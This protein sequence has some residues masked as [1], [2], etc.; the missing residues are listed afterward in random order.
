MSGLSVHL[1]VKVMEY[2]IYLAMVCLASYRL[3]WLL[4]SWRERKSHRTRI[5][6]EIQEKREK[7]IRRSEE[8]PLATRFNKAGNPLFL[9]ALKFQII[10][11]SIFSGVAI[12]YLLGPLINE[13]H[14]SLTIFGLIL[15]MLVATSPML[16]ISLTNVALNKLIEFHIRK[17]HIELFTLFDMLKAELRSLNQQ[18]HVNVYHLLNGSLPYFDSIDSGI[19]KFLRFW[20]V[21]PE[22]AREVFIKEIGGDH[23][24]Q[25]ANILF[26]LDE[27]SRS[28]AVEVIDG[29]SK[30]FS[31]DYFETANRKTE[32]KS[33]AFNVLFFGANI[34]TLIWLIVMVVSMF[35]NTFSQVNL[36][37]Y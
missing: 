18:Q 22:K 34:L 4:T 6:K 33:I 20:K 28:Y 7:V 32:G 16:K 10:R 3:Y 24:E 1:L 14:I 30:V 12:Y 29:A 19:T 35:S 8:T 21:D 15:L 23:A 26:R 37:G 11:Y 25:L 2:G 31:A 17:K 9:T 13:Q 5:Q 27:T 36:G